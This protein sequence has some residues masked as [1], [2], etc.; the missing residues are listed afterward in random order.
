[1]L[2]LVLNEIDCLDDVD[3]VQ[4]RGNA[5]LGGELLDIFLLRFILSPLTEFLGKT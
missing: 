1:M 3:M 4:G 5:V 2:I